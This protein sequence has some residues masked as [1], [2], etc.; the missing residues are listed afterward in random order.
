M[1]LT[2]DAPSSAVSS[3]QSDVAAPSA[4]AKERTFAFWAESEHYRAYGGRQLAESPHRGRI[5]A[6]MDGRRSL[7]D[8]ACGD[9][10]NLP[11]LPEG[12]DYLG[13]DCS[14]VALRRLHERDDHRPLAKRG[15]VGDCENLPLPDASVEVVLSTFALEHFTDVPRVLDEIDRVLQ[16]GGRVL[17]IGPDFGF[18]NNFGPPQHERLLG[19]RLPLLAYATGRVLSKAWDRLR[20]RVS[21]RYIEPLP[22]DDASYIP[23]ADMTHLTDHAAIA[24]HLRRRGYRRLLLEPSVRPPAG[25][26]KRLLHDLHL[27]GQ[28][29]D[30][31]LALQKPQHTAGGTA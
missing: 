19:R 11:H 21:F 30:V 8:L 29:G 28:N 16:P 17:F 1:T 27:W 7:L 22:L 3:E 24:R 15:L 12:T 20:G 5:G 13:L 9:G 31:L 26:L 25:G 2:L 4:T 6:L 14:P 10:N 23:D 18:P